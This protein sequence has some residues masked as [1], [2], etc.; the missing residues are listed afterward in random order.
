MKVPD[1]SSNYEDFVSIGM[2]TSILLGMHG[3]GFCC[4]KEKKGKIHVS[5]SV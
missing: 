5:F 2:K 4:E 1:A 3:H